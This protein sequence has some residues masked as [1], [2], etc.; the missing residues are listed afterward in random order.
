MASSNDDYTP[1]GSRYSTA[2]PSDW[3]EHRVASEASACVCR[4]VDDWGWELN[5]YARLNKNARVCQV[6]RY[7]IHI[8]AFDGYGKQPEVLNWQ[9]PDFGQSALWWLAMHGN[10]DLVRMLLDAGCDANLSDKD[11][12]SPLSVAAFY[13]HASV[14]QLLLERGADASIEVED[15]DTAYDKAVIWDHPECMV[16]LRGLM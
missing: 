14:V 7:E 5:K 10:V 6:L 9:D 13:G 3:S 11:G 1:A 4:Y 2:W 16:L 12:W 15:G 8:E